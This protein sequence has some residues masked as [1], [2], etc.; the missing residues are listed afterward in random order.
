MTPGAFRARS[1]Q[2]HFAPQDAE[3]LRQLVD[4][5]LA[6]KGSDTGDSRI[7]FG[8]PPGH[9]VVFRVVAHAAE[10][11]AG[12]DASAETDPRLAIDDGPGTVEPDRNHR[13]QHDRRE[14]GQK[15]Q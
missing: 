6:D 4:A 3:E 2:A 9:S 8:G 5:R 10:L 12:E 15:K 11:Q 7:V 14:N 1:D 13:E